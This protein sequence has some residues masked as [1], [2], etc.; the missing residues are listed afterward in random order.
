MDGPRYSNQEPLWIAVIR[1]DRK[2]EFR[3]KKLPAEV[4]AKIR[5]KAKTWDDEIFTVPPAAEGGV[6][7]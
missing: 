2:V 1:P 3:D 5:Q 4:R 7:V 6:A